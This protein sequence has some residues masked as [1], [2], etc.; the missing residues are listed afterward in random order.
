[1]CVGVD[2]AGAGEPDSRP[3]SS[4]VWLG[5]FMLA[6]RHL[7]GSDRRRALHNEN[8]SIKGVAAGPFGRPIR[9]SVATTCAHRSSAK[10]LRTHR[11]VSDLSALGSS[12]GTTRDPAPATEMEFRVRTGKNSLR[13]A[14]TAV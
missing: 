11:R 1:M 12:E 8:Y 14:M 2:A 4:T 13:S 3:G 9:A 5:S 10:R 7:A 6:V